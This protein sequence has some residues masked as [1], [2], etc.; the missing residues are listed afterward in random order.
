[1]LNNRETVYKK[2]GTVKNLRKMQF[3]NL[4]DVDKKQGETP[5]FQTSE[6]LGGRNEE[7]YDEYADDFRSQNVYSNEQKIQFNMLTEFE[8]SYFILKRMN[9]SD[10]LIFPADFKE[11]LKVLCPFKS[12]N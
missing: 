9:Q 12:N 5:I 7:S 10:F 2:T 6:S 3:I 11:D 4:K 8:T 1:M